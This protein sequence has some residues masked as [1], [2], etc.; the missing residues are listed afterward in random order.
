[1]K[2]HIKLSLVLLTILLS[3]HSH[4]MI[5]RHVT[6]K[7]MRASRVFVRNQSSLCDIKPVEKKL[8]GDIPY[9]AFKGI[10]GGLC[11]GAVADVVVDGFTDCGEVGG[12]VGFVAGTSLGGP[13][14]LGVGVSVVGLGAL[15]VYA[16]AQMEKNQKK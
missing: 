5:I 16:N 9:K 1:M 11:V 4:S 3:S 13:V 14:G 7:I 6:P 15:L 12:I 8:P 2:L 10:V